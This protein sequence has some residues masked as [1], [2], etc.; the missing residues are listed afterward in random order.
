MSTPEP[1]LGQVAKDVQEEGTVSGSSTIDLGGVDAETQALIKSIIAQGSSG[2]STA[3]DPDLTRGRQAYVD[4]WGI[5]PPKGY[6]ESLVKQGLNP[7]EIRA[8]ELSK[9]DANGKL[10]AEGTNYWRDDWANKAAVVAQ[11]MGKR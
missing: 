3:E 2:T 11:A 4:V 10:L 5:D 9:V 8:H 7:Y 1:E 6:I